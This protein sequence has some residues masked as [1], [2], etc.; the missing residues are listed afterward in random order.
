MDLEEN[1][2][3]LWEPF[4]PDEPLERLY[5]KF[6]ERVD[7]AT[8]AGDPVMEGQIVLITHGIVAETGKF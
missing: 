5:T 3:K 8:V 7:Y 2:T 1:E 4:N 6:N